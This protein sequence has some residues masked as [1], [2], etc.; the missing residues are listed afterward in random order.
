LGAI[1]TE[2][3]VRTSGVSRV[4]AGVGADPFVFAELHQTIV[5]RT[6]FT[7]G[8]IRANRPEVFF[9]IRGAVHLLVTDALIWQ[10]LIAIGAAIIIIDRAA[11][12][13]K[14]AYDV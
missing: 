5:S 4:A 10:I 1:G 11:K 14:H 6:A 3:G 7:A 12:Q 9:Q 2:I 13:K 8:I